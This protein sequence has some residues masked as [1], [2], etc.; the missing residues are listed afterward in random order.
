MV[1]DGD[2]ESEAVDEGDVV[3]L[4]DGLGL[5]VGVVLHDPVIVAVRDVEGD[6]V[7]DVD[8][9]VEVDGD[10]VTDPLGLVEVDAED[11]GLT[12]RV[13]VGLGEGHTAHS[14]A[15]GVVSSQRLYWSR[16]G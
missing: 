11:V 3:S 5:A 9:L 15:V 10:E 16:P 12:V 2:V 13:A 4:N 6:A 14:L 7:V 8:G 1:G